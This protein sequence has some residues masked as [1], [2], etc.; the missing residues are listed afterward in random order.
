MLKTHR[1]MCAA[2]LTVITLSG[3]GTVSAVPDSYCRIANPI[4]FSDQ[5]TAETRSQI[6]EHNAAWVCACEADCP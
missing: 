6:E 5:D 3:C 2:I 1:T 4:T